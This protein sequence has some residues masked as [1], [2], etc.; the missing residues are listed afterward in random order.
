[1]FQD[2]FWQ[3]LLETV[4]IQKI[5]T[6][7]PKGRKLM[8][9]QDKPGFFEKKSNT[10]FLLFSLP[11]IL[12]VLFLALYFYLSGAFEPI[13]KVEI[14]PENRFKKTLHVVT[15]RDYKPYSYIDETKLPTA[16]K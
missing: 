13:P 8:E 10:L 7:L 4:I 2:F 14:Q 9:L 6:H 3:F 1:M 15:D 5:L 12:A 16:L 11:A